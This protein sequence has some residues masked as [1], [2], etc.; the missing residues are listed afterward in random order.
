MYPLHTATQHTHATTPTRKA[1][2]MTTAT[3][4]PANAYLA[5]LLPHATP[6]GKPQRGNW[7][8]YSPDSGKLVLLYRV[9]GN[10]VMV[11]GFNNRGERNWQHPFD[12]A[13]AQRHYASQR[14]AGLITAHERILLSVE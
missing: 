14:R 1:T 11:D 9:D 7:A 2:A 6:A 4:T 8:L 3:A 10:S 5:R 13:E 12:R